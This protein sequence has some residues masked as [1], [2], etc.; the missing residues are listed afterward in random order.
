MK[1]HLAALALACGQFNPHA[2]AQ[3]PALEFNSCAKPTWPKEALRHEYQG[4]VTLALLIAADGTVRKS[5]LEKSSG[6]PI[7][8]LAA[9]ESIERCKFKPGKIDGQPGEG[10]QLMQYVWT[11]EDK[12]PAVMAAALTQARAG[13]ERGEAADQNKLGLIYLNG[14]GVDRDMV[15]AKKWL[16]M[17]AHQG[18]SEAQYT[19][20]MLAMPRDGKAD[21]QEAM[22][23]FR[24]AA[25]QGQARSQYYLG[26]YL[27]KRG[28]NDQ[29]RI[30]LDKAAR[31]GHSGA[32]TMLS[33]LLVSAG[34]PEDQAEAV[35]LLGKA[36]AQDDRSA[37]L[38]LGQRYE[39]GNGVPQDYAQAAKLYNKAAVAG[40]KMGKAALVRLQENGHS[41]TEDTSR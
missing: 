17:A 24:K 27:L 41:T 25:D 19:L 31:Q 6:Y 3:T 38:L 18:S 29:A 4:T 12:N 28:D 5:R 1:K 36:A 40:N 23:W 10:W 15:E 7:L 30:L 14:Q 2:W 39:T 16:F 32:Q 35:A 37:Q 20:G 9:Q 22:D 13:A 8:D 33:Q 34:Q 11:L 26:A 21:M